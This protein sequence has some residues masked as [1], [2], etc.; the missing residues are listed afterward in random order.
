MVLCESREQAKTDCIYGSR[1]GSSQKS[2][3]GCM[4]SG[5][6]LLL[7]LNVITW[8]RQCLSGSPRGRLPFPPSIC[9]TWGQEGPVSSPACS[10]SRELCSTSS[11]VE[12]PHKSF[13]IL[14]SRFSSAFISLVNHL[15]MT[16]WTRCR[17]GVIFRHCLVHVF[18]QT[19]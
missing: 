16:G 8:P 3:V 18:A 15:F 5:H 19:C 6:F 7:M 9:C 2:H 10:R 11:G 12:V 14:K 1:R 17:L 4:L 13:E